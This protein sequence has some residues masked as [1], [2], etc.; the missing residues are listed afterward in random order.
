MKKNELKEI[1]QHGDTLFHVSAYETILQ[2]NFSVPLY[3]HWHN[4]LEFFYIVSGNA[5]MRLN[6]ENIHISAGDI[7]VIKPNV[8]HGSYDC[9]QQ[10]L[11]FRAVLIDYEFVAGILNDIVQQK[12]IA[13]LFEED[14]SAFYLIK[15]EDTYRSEL[16]E[17][18]NNIYEIF[19]K[20]QE[21]YEIKIK[22]L[23]FNAF[24]YLYPSISQCRISKPI[25]T[26]KDATMKKILKYIDKNYDN[27]ILLKDLAKEVSMSEG[28]L[29]RFF[30]INFKMTF[31]DY[32]LNTRIQKAEILVRNTDYSMELIAMKTGF[33]NSNYFTIKFKQVFKETP[34]KYRK[35]SQD[36]NKIS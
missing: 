30:K 16:F 6:G 19:E 29:C 5:K 7:V 11:I 14:N 35:K 28:Y 13:P 8:L 22:S 27:K 26:M 24:Y 12:Y 17:E 31:G 9:Y 3:Y 33:T 21:G 15:K 18:L 20:K 4:E 25:D 1:L 10:A 36:F 32:L 2:Q 23:I 34:T